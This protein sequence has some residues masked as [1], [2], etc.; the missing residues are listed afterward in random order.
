MGAGIVGGANRPPY[1]GQ[2]RCHQNGNKS[3]R[4]ETAPQAQPPPT[5]G[6]NKEENEI[7]RE[8]E[9]DRNKGA[10]LTEIAGA[11]TWAHASERRLDLVGS[12]KQISGQHNGS[13]NRVERDLLLLTTIAK[14]YI[15]DEVVRESSWV[16]LQL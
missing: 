4:R 16:H 3:G 11:R 2:S 14:I 6:K 12:T 13:G 8:K 9:E 7:K 15:Y 5:Y 10:T 1:D